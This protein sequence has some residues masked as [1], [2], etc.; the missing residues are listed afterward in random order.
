MNSDT[1][2]TI[3]FGKWELWVE[4]ADRLSCPAL[5]KAKSL[6]L[7]ILLGLI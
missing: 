7:I 3:K 2:R 6:L 4:K 1:I 5:A